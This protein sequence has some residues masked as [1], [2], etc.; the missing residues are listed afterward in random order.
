MN[1]TTEEILKELNSCKFEYLDSYLR[2]TDWSNIKPEEIIPQMKLRAFLRSIQDKEI[3]L[4]TARFLGQF[5]TDYFRESAEQYIRNQVK[6]DGLGKLSQDNM[7]AAKT[8]GIMETFRRELNFQVDL[9]E[10]EGKYSNESVKQL[11]D[12]IAELEEQ[13]RVL[14]DEKAKLET[15]IDR[16]KNPLK[17]RKYVP[18]KLQTRF[19]EDI[20]TYLYNHQILYSNT[21]SHL[22]QSQI[23]S[24]HW[25]ANHDLF[26]YFVDR[27]NFELEL[28]DSGGRL[29]WKLFKAAF[30]NYEDIYRTAQNTVAKYKQNPKLRKPENSE[31]I[32]EAIKFAS[33]YEAERNIQESNK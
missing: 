4:R 27:M 17:N 28:A 32:D 1:I 23:S 26:G 24:F 9:I 7:V 15:I 18:A 12:K 11:Q 8:N 29:N 2:N 3:R 21:T 19:F 30:D 6:A 16:Y 31:I 5:A 20:I 10:Q 13:V 33:A 25:V 22:G 14:E